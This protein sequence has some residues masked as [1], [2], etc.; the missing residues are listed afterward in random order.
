MQ[1]F[2]DFVLNNIIFFHLSVQV[3]YLREV[4]KYL[5]L[6]CVIREEHFSKRS[7]VDFNIDCFRR[8]LDLVVENDPISG[9]TSGSGSGIP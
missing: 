5:A 3:L 1:I 4:S 7:L 9:D 8:S 6:V 2:F